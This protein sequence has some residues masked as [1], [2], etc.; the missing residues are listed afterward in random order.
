LFWN[1]LEVKMTWKQKF[2]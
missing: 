2:C 1:K